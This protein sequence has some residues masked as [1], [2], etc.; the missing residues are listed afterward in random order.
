MITKAL[1]PGKAVEPFNFVPDSEH[2]TA[3]T[4]LVFTPKA[5]VVGWV[6]GAYIL[7]FKTFASGGS[8]P[9]APGLEDCGY[10]WGEDGRDTPTRRGR[11][12][13]RPW[14]LMDYHWTLD[15]DLEGDFW[16]FDEETT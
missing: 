9:A 16:Y 4:G 15:A 11:I 8:G 2:S 5:E 7:A 1:R 14:R 12:E 3:D 13:L 6:D 10:N